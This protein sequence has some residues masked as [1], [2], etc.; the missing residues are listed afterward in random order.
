MTSSLISAWPEIFFQPFPLI[1][2]I[3]LTLFIIYYYYIVFKIK[4]RRRR[5]Q[6]R[7]AW[8]D[9]ISDLME[10]NQKTPADSEGHRSLVCCSPWGRRVKHNLETEQQQQTGSD[11]LWP[12]PTRLLCLRSSP[13]RNIGVC[14]HFLLQAIFPTQGSNPSLQCLLHCYADSLPLGQPTGKP[15][16]WTDIHR[17]E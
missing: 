7:M 17:D 16:L 4:G 3:T 12:Q 14:C 5:G 13:G 15:S 8:L 9:S 6:Q 10:M 1:N 11:S 2:I